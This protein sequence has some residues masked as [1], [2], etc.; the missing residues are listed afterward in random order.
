VAWKR[1]AEANEV[2]PAQLVER[3]QQM[4]LIREP[5]FVLRDDGGAI[6]VWADPERIA[7]FAAAADIDGPG[8][9]RQSLA[10]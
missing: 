4:V 8:R 10:C 6:A 3:A 5:A 2:A 1:R 9:G 7:P